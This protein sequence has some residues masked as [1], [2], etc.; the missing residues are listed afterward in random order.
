MGESNIDPVGVYRFKVEV[1]GLQVGG[2]AEIQGLEMELETE[3][4][5]EGGLNNLVHNLP[6]KVKFKNL[7]FKRGVTTNSVLLDWFNDCTSGTIS[8]KNGSVM[9]Y[10]SEGYPVICWIFIAAYPVKCSWSSLNAKGAQE[11][12]IE[13]IE[14]AH[15]GIRVRQG[16]KK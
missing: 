7:V 12:A 8:R 10:D 1:D 3:E 15:S 16:Y 14:F 6:K 11:V 4:I 2:F 13:T 5:K 9:L